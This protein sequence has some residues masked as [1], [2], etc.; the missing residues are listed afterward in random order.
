MAGAHRSW[1]PW[2]P[3]GLTFLRLLL[4]PVML[5]NAMTMRSRMFFLVCLS[6]AFV[7]D[8]YDG[9]LARRLGVASPR[10]RRFD[11]VTDIV[12]YISAL[13]CI[14]IVHPEIVREF[15]PAIAALVGL[16]AI[17]QSISLLKFHHTA[18]IHAYSAKLWGIFLFAAICAVLVWDSTGILFQAMLAVGFVAYAEW[19]AILLLGRGDMVDVSSVLQAWRSR[20]FE[21]AI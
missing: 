18:A 7:S 12:F 21:T 10:L 9:V 5:A 14:W 8:I 13:I 16:E 15:W 1:A 4:A 11:S 19:I 20:R 3:A 17:G 6:T 2:L